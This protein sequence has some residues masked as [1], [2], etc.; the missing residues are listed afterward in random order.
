MDEG[1]AA[2]ASYPRTTGFNLH[3][4]KLT[5]GEAGNRIRSS[6]AAIMPLNSTWLRPLFLKRISAEN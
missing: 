5:S 6:Q 2:E 3:V 1:A 4:M